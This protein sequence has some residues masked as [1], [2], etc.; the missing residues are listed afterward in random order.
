MTTTVRDRRPFSDY[1]PILGPV[2][3]THATSKPRI[4]A[5]AV[6]CRALSVGIAPGIARLW[7]RSRGGDRFDTITA[8][9]RSYQS[10]LTAARRKARAVHSLP[11]RRRERVAAAR[12]LVGFLLAPRPAETRV[13]PHRTAIARHALA[14]IGLEILES[15]ETKGFTTALMPSARLSVEMGVEQPVAKSALKACIELGW[16]RIVSQK[17]GGSG[18]YA[19]ARLPKHCGVIADDFT[20]TVDALI[21]GPPHGDRVAEVIAVAADAAVGYDLNSKCWLAGLIYAVESHVSDQIVP[22]GSAHDLNVPV[23]T[24]KALRRKWCSALTKNATHG[25]EPIAELLDRHA[26]ATGADARKVDA[27]TARRVAA[28]ARKALTE[29]RRDRKTKAYRALDR[30]LADAPIPRADSRRE[31]VVAWGEDLRARIAENNLPVDFRRVL[32]KALEGRMARAGFEPD[33]AQVAA[34]VIVGVERKEVA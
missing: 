22:V 3:K 15:I 26:K 18:R 13:S 21:S 17:P 4:A 34:Q 30:L 29:A 10:V 7:L 19:L 28:A 1:D 14:I 32:A 6:T 25:H 5:L 33:K 27:E 8:S 12:R 11:A 9:P 16:L 31:K 24:I 23:K 20:F 2:L